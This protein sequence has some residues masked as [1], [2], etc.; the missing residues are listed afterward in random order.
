MTVAMDVD[1]CDVCGSRLLLGEIVYRRAPAAGDDG[2]LGVVLVHDDC[3]ERDAHVITTR[4]GATVPKLQC[5]R[6]VFGADEGGEADGG[7]Q[8]GG[9]SLQGLAVARRLIQAADVAID[10][11]WDDGAG[12]AERRA[13]RFDVLQRTTT[14]ISRLPGLTAQQME[15]LCSEVRVMAGMHQ[16]L[17]TQE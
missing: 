14:E 6:I 13:I 15:E 4:N 5:S 12:R 8:G 9:P 7:G 3:V 11:A 1:E 2:D 10:E 16:E 17:D